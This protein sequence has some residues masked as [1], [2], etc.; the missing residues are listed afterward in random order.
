MNGAQS[1]FK[2][3]TDAG[4]DT[5]FANPGTSEMQ[6]VYEMGRTDAVRAVLCLQE[7]V[8]TGAAD[9]YARMAGKPAFTLLHVG[10]GFA[11]GIANLHNAG[12]ANTPIVNVVGANA[13]YHQHNYPE[14][15]LVG[16]KIT[17]LAR[18]VSH[19]SREAKSAADLAVLGVE[20]VRNARTG[21][22][23]IS[24]L[25]APTNCHWD[26]AP[27]APV[28]DATA[29]VLRVSP[30]A[31]AETA[32]RLTS[33]RKTALLLGSRALYGE[34]LE[35]AGQ[36]AAST[37][38]QLLVETFPP[39]LARGEGSVK[40]QVVP[41]I[42]E[43]AKQVFSDYE[44]IILVGALPPV[45]TFAYQGSETCKLPEGCEA[46]P[47][48]TTDHDLR[49]ALADLAE[50]TG[51]SGNEF[52]RV[53]R[54]EPEVPTG[55]LTPAA[56]GQ[57]INLLMPENAITVDE[58]ATAGLEIFQE[59]IGARKHDF[60]NAV[61]G[62]AIGAGLP[63]ALGAAV[64]CPERKVVS[65]AADGSTMYTNQ[66]LW[67]IA[68]EGC[69]VTIVVLKNDAYAI[70]EVELARVREGDVT[71][72]MQSMMSIN[73][74]SIDWVKLAGGMGV[75]AVAVATAEAFH[76]AFGKAMAQKGPTLIEAS[77]EQDL[78]PLVD[79]IMQKRQT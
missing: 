64:A 38:A 1:L 69:D 3:L 60:L 67:S 68:R 35:L 14:H 36:I 28:A 9:G 63:M 43:M 19:W 26:P 16:G 73:S 71:P 78:Q 65:L 77:I 13:S 29:P 47:L 20:A 57:S 74:P 79:V 75:P 22:G 42:L 25:I 51:A 72:K 11:N 48:A 2:V 66:G 15:E 27:D 18:A 50:A 17:E 62:G 61:T 70:L 55:A 45:S 5:C 49:A 53:E 10:S 4:L 31:V 6:L 8:V 59:T 23:R 34:P 58:G 32:Q 46:W 39:R 76:E 54:V 21:A 12:R 41:Y 7:N 40:V 52:A 44:Q 56:L 33:G 30:A 24:T 37:G